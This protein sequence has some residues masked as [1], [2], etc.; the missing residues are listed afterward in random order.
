MT[1]LIRLNF[2]RVQLMGPTRSIFKEAFS[3]FSHPKQAVCSAFP[4]HPATF[5]VN[6]KSRS[7]AH[8]IAVCSTSRSLLLPPPVIHHLTQRICEWTPT[9][10][11]GRKGSK[12]F[13]EGMFRACWWYGIWLWVCFLFSAHAGLSECLSIGRSTTGPGWQISM[14]TGWIII[15]SG[16]QLDVSLRMTI[17]VS[18]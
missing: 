13:H 4:P 1:K 12:T 10:V 8:S 5:T 16:A 17:L 7:Q 3:V 6:F 18:P 9:T 2:S 14:V 11:A 15:K